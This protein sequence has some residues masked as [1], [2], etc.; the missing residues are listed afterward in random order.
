MS[1]FELALAA[2]LVPDLTNVT[3]GRLQLHFVNKDKHKINIWQTYERHT[4]K[5]LSD[6][7]ALN[8]ERTGTDRP[9]P[10]GPV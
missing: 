8:A 1:F 6:L 7:R 2:V 3:L 9:P 10:S 5:M 4:L